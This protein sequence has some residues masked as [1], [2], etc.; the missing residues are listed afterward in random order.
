[1]KNKEE[2][3][4]KPGSI[5]LTEKP[6]V[7]V[8]KSGLRNQR[9]DF[10]FKRANLLRCSACRYVYYCGR[11]CQKQGWTEHKYECPYLRQIFP[12]ILPDAARVMSKIILKL[13]KGGD[14]ERGYY[15]STNFRKFKD[16]MS[17][18]TDLKQDSKRI[19]HFTSLCAVIMDFLGES[20]LPNSAE[21]MGIY[22]RM[23]VNGFNILDPEMVSI[24]TGI[25]LGASVIDHSCDP[26]A[27]AVF[28]GTTL[29]IRAVK[30]MPVLDWKKVRI[31]YIDLLNTPKARQAELQATYY[32][33][34]DCSRCLDAEELKLM[35]SLQCPSVNCHQPI[36]VHQDDNDNPLTCSKC[37]QE[38]KN[39]TLKEYQEVQE[40]TIQQLEKMK[41]IAYL[42]V[43]KLCL[44]K[45][46]GLFHQCNLLHVKVLDMAFESS[47]ELGLW[48]QAKEMGQE[49]VQGYRQYYGDCHPL[50]G[51]FYLKLGKISLYLLDLKTARDRLSEAERILRITHGEKHVLYQEELM[52]LIEQCQIDGL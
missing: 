3:S 32:F 10:C 34:C 46:Q 42:D 8:L 52:Q 30:P 38:I 47:I 44:N 18:Y 7:C 12:R 51:I 45:Q 49:L 23:C 43:C 11:D 28:E 25:Y 17:H 5:L 14:Q 33:L 41:E 22:G 19:E 50:T 26:N 40:F 1:M 27:V 6:F 29:H 2:K 9:C 20:N 31:T 35:D 48:E 13:Q 21:L 4:V 15:T 24:G 37:G 16:L 39:D 36:P